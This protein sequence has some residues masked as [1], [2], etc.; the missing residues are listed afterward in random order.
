[1][2]RAERH[3]ERRRLGGREAHRTGEVVGVVDADDP[4]TLERL[5]VDLD[6]V[7]GQA[8]RDA[9]HEEQPQVALDLVG[10]GPE[11]RSGVVEAHLAA[12][13]QVRHQCEQPGDLVGRGVCGL[14]RHRAPPAATARRRATT[15]SRS[16]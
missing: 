10:V 9:R 11:V 15:S 5:E 14:R 3:H 1:V 4:V 2:P 8:G 12:R 13:E 16:V 6:Q 7:P